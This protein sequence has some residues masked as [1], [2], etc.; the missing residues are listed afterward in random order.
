MEI[1]YDVILNKVIKKYRI[2]NNL[3][4]FLKPY[5]SGAFDLHFFSSSK[6]TTIM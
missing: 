4:L 5:N 3:K 1:Y 2:V 6:L